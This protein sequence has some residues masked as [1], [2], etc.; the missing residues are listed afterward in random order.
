MIIT[1]DQLVRAG[2]CQEALNFFSKHYPDGVNAKAV[3]EKGH[4][5]DHFYHWAYN[6]LTV[7]P[8]DIEAYLK[9]MNIVDSEGVFDSR[10][11]SNSTRVVRSQRVNHS[12]TIYKST[13]VDN[14]SYVS[15]SDDVRYSNYV[16][17]STF[18]ENSKH[19]NKSHNITD[20]T[21]VY[22]TTYAVSSHSIFVSRNVVN[23]YDIRY[24]ENLSDCFMCVDCTNSNHLFCCHG[25]DNGEYMIFNEKVNEKQWQMIVNQYLRF[26]PITRIMEKWNEL[27]A[28]AP[29]A[30]YNYSTH[31]L[32]TPDK[33][34][35]WLRTLP[36]YT[37]QVVYNIT[38]RRGIL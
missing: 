22:D 11:V 13:D 2:A 14:S 29:P 27:S 38:F 36:N 21:D 1:L 32:A 10:D 9:H 30:I 4:L 24:G 25:V 3:I 17:L 35:S 37:P 23:C 7:D 5:P 16:C 8:E 34:W 28:E 20:S 18:V 33:F 31:Y 15:G 19:I 26:A 6:E 12:Y